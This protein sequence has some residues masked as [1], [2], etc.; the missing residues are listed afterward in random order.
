[1]AAKN[2]I[3]KSFERVK[4]E[5]YGARFYRVDLHFHT[6][7][8]D[9]ARGA[10]KYGWK[11]Y[12]NKTFPKK[13][14]DSLEYY[15]EVK[16]KQEEIIE[17]CRKLA[18]DIV[19]RFRDEKINLV[20]ITDHNSIGTIWNDPESTK[21]IM[22]LAAP[23][24]YE[25]IDDEAQELNKDRTVLTILPGVEISTSDIHILAIFPPQKPRRKV[26]FIIC[27]LLNEMGFDV[28]AWGTNKAGKTGVY[29]T[30][31]LIAQKGGLPIIA[32]ADAHSKAFFKLYK[33]KSAA[34]KDV[35]T[36]KNLSA[37]EIKKFSH[38]FKWNKDLDGILNTWIRS[39]RTPQGL[40]SIAYF[41]GSDAH[42][43]EPIGQPYNYTF[44]KMNEPSFSGLN[45]AVHM[46]AGRIML[47]DDLQKLQKQEKK[48][49]W[50]IYGLEINHPYFKKRTIRFNRF[51]NCVVGRLESGKTTL[52]QLMQQPITPGMHDRE[53]QGSIRIFIEKIVDAQSYYY[54]MGK[55]SKN[56]YLYSLDKKENT[57]RKMD[58]QQFKDLKIMP[59]FYEPDIVNQ[60][61]ASGEAFSG[62]MERRFGP[63]NEENIKK[64]NDM[65]AVSLFVGEEKQQ[66]L[67]AEADSGHYKL[68]LNERWNRGKE[69]RIEFSRLDNSL[70][71]ILLISV[72]TISGTTGPLII[73]SP[74]EYINNHDIV[75]YLVPIIKK[76]KDRRQMIVFTNHPLFAVNTDPE[77]YILLEQKKRRGK[78]VGRI[79]LGFSID[80]EEQK[81][82]LITLMEGS[83]DA[84]N[85][86]KIRYDPMV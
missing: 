28:D 22:D 65:F 26:H 7:A 24:W 13:E 34:M 18:K 61:I 43:T 63:P 44:V 69:K 41:Q 1:M 74:E 82:A 12:D 71:R 31:Q 46:P 8:S 57:V 33:M 11:Y 59:R 35:L 17:E 29:N 6:P 37:I 55:D 47:Y 85:K 70:R 27:D 32:H 53:I 23:T 21:D 14:G 52:S 62:F 84:Y 9:D 68:Y 16:K 56:Q 54:V 50:Y 67:Y 38:Y 19:Q 3:I 76:Y 78:K 39:L 66:L 30:I 10:D 42:S 20:A 40:S 58:W 72:I 75:N 86:R 15:K 36:N 45:A 49:G 2:T 48:S 64:F 25:L 83:L 73:D 5:D 60:L 81:E 79:K 77:N 4:A 51:L 80:K